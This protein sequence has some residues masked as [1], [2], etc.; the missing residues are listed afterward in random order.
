MH[1]PNFPGIYGF[2]PALTDWQ[3]WSFCSDPPTEPDGRRF[4]LQQHG[5]IRFERNDP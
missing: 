5:A 2:M 4:F 3:M 1:H